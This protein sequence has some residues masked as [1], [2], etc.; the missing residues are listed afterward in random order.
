MKKAKFRFWNID[1]WAYITIGE[2]WTDVTKAIY[3]KACINGVKFYQLAP[4]EDAQ[5]KEV[6]DGDIYGYENEDEL[7][8]VFIV[9]RRRWGWGN[10]FK[11]WAEDVPNSMLDYYCFVGTKKL[12]NIEQNPEL[13]K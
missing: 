8:S 2:K 1:H 13:M 10:Q 6:Y 9:K 7:E 11:S 4:F 5:G 3:N 12:G